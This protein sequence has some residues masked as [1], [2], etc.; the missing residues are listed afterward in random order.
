MVTTRQ[1]IRNKTEGNTLSKIFLYA[2]RNKLYSFK[3]EASHQEY[4]NCTTT[5]PPPPFQQIFVKTKKK[6]SRKT[7]QIGLQLLG[8]SKSFESDIY[9]AVE[10]PKFL[11]DYKISTFI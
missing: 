1:K 10:E 8:C 9:R 7:H 6:I 2:K 4:E 5:T 11:R 3:E